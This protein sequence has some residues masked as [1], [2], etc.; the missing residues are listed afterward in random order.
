[1]AEIKTIKNCRCLPKVQVAAKYT[2][3]DLKVEESIVLGKDNTTANFLEKFPLGKVPVMTAE[4]QNIFE[5]DALLSYAGAP[6]LTGSTDLERA[7]IQQWLSFET[8]VVRPAADVWW[9]PIEGNT[10]YNKG[11]ETKAKEDIKK[12]LSVLNSHLR[13]RTYL[14]GERISIAD[15]AIVCH[16]DVLYKNLLDPEFRAAYKHTNRWFTT[17]RNQPEFKSVLGEVTLASKM[18]T[19][20][21]KKKEV[22]KPKADKPAA[23]A[24]PAAEEKPKKKDV[25]GH[26]PKSTFNIEE[27]KRVYSNEDE[28][29]SIAWFWENFDKEGYAI[30]KADYKYN[31]ELALVFM[32]CNLITGMFQRLDSMRKYAFGS[33]CVFGENNKNEIHGI[34]V[35][36]GQ[37]LPFPLSPDWQV[38]YES[39]EFT[40]LNPDDQAAKEYVNAFLKWENFP[41]TLPAFNQGKIY[42]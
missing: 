34:W 21:P 9:F 3:K 10:P 15:I 12:A 7:L 38:D 31:E 6:A 30:W 4:G 8:T 25:F 17:C 35:V 36:R 32:S 42:K 28:D 2:G 13:S 29:K 20:Q 5:S 11:A 39:Y 27:F 26:L 41:S 37:E 16:L 22:T 40:K 19:Y 23:A 14:I 18:A 24:A 33:V 1:M